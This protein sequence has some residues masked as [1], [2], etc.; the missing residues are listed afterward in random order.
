MATK[1]NSTYAHSRVSFCPSANLFATS[2]HG[3]KPTWPAV[4]RCPVSGVERKS[5]F[6]GGRSVDDPQQTFDVQQRRV[7][8][9]NSN[10]G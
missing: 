3:T 5:D 9:A 10:E 8:A 6:E 4:R 2:V 7:H 1:L